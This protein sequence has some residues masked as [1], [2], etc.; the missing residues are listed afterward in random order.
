MDGYLS[1]GVM[2][3][4]NYSQTVY[5]YS[6]TSTTWSVPSSNVTSVTF[7]AWGGGGKGY[8]EPSSPTVQTSYPGGGGA[9]YARTTI[10]NPASG[11][12]FTLNVGQGSTS[13]G[14][15]GGN[16]TIVSGVTT[17]CKAAGGK[18]PSSGGSGGQGGQVADC[19]GDVKYAGGNG[20]GGCTSNCGLPG[21]AGG[22]AAG[23]NGAAAGSVGASEFGGN[24]GSGGAAT[25]PSD[26]FNNGS[27]GNNYG[28]GGGGGNSYNNTNCSGGNGAIGLIRIT[29]TTLL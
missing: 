4:D 28:A 23:S 15:A 14:V 16:T 21:G 24:G 3:G 11:A 8:G 12:T 17:Y 29:Y 1:S 10:L 20:G 18:S 27:P 19:I 6:G 9:A 26:T 5:I 13:E 7:E 25:G 22:G 2:A